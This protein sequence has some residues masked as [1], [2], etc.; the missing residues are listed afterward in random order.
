MNRPVGIHFWM[1][2]VVQNFKFLAIAALT[3]GILS[4]AVGFALPKTYRARASVLPPHEI[5]RLVALQELGSMFQ[6]EAI[7]PFAAG[8]TL[9]DIYLG[10][11]DSDE[12]AR[13]LNEEFDLQ[14][15]YE[16]STRIRTIKRLRSNTTIQYTLEGIV[17]VIV[18]DKDPKMAADL[19]NAYMAQLDR[20]FRES[21]SSTSRRQREFLERRFHQSNET[22]DRLEKDL[23]ELQSAGGMTA[24]TKDA[25][26][27]AL[28]AGDLM[29]QRLALSVQ[30]E[31]F[32]ELEIGSAPVKQQLESELRA[33]ERELARL[34]QIG[35][36]IGKQLR[37][38]R[39]QERLHEALSRQVEMARLEEVRDTAVVDV[40]DRAV[41]PDRHVWPRKSLLGILGFVLALSAGLVFQAMRWTAP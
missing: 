41:V 39:I 36:G 17:E 14:S 5:D 15:H 25:S 33:V 4:V 31:M 1:A 3:G 30:L 34:P 20:V 2:L 23:A 40:L 18:D 26:E 19:A 7:K 22:L 38:L 28:A 32:S 10:I 16:T 6:L 9:L 35:L 12:V 13:S 37:D 11:L 29:G 27:A 24:L 8:I 21:K